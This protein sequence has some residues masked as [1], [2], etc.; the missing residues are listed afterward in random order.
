[1]V[2]KKCSSMFRA[3]KGIIIM[4]ILLCTINLQMF[5]VKAS[6]CS[7][8]PNCSD[9]EFRYYWGYWPMPYEAVGKGKSITLY[10]ND[11]KENRYCQCPKTTGTSLKWYKFE[12]GLKTE[13][14]ENSAH[15]KKRGDNLFL[16]NMGIENSGLFSCELR[17]AENDVILKRNYTLLVHKKGKVSMP[18]KDIMYSGHVHINKTDKNANGVLDCSFQAMGHSIIT[19]YKDE[20]LLSAH[21]DKYDTKL[22]AGTYKCKV[23]T[24]VGGFSQKFIVH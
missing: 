7:N 9:L 10:C 3:S 23:S 12:N 4:M 1:M 19:W 20:Q 6:E 22:S 13:I 18:V 21:S 5:E 11:Y 2:E 16:K 15:V 17:N 8:H 14:T 24:N